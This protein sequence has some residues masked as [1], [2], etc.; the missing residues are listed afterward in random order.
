MLGYYRDRI[1]GNFRPSTRTAIRRYQR[2]IG[3]A[4]TGGLTAE[5]AR[6]LI[7]GAASRR[8]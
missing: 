5:Q 2:E 3:E 4:A 6:R 7:A 1:D 8:R